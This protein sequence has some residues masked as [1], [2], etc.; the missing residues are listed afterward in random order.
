[1]FLNEFCAHPK[2]E[3]EKTEMPL[4]EENP[5]IKVYFKRWIILSIFCLVTVMNN[6]NWIEHNIIQDVTVAFYN[7]SLPEGN[8]HQQTAVNWLSMVYMLVYIP[9]IFPAMYFLDRKG[10]KLTVLLGASLTFL[11]AF[12]KCF[13]V[14][15]NLF[16]VIM[17]G[18]TLCSI[19]QAFILS[20]PARLSAVWFGSNEVAS[21]TAIGVLGNQLG[22][23]I[24]F[25]VPPL[26]VK[27]G[28]VDDMKT[29]FYYLYISNA[30]VCFVMTLLTVFCKL[31]QT[32]F[33]LSTSIKI[34]LLLL[35]VVSDQPKIPPSLSQLEV[36]SERQIK[37]EE[38]DFFLFKKSVIALLKN[39][40]FLLVFVSYGMNVGV[41]YAISTLLNQ[42]ISQYYP[43]S[44]FLKY[45]GTMV[46]SFQSIYFRLE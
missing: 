23:A 30:A 24:G 44:S 26:V 21:A 17:L 35:K 19:A 11:G 39:A 4:D 27:L 45:L 25:L 3:R 7:E 9:T 16:P 22:C 8:I 10:L 1:M 34:F 14:E 32:K 15:P 18:Q 28:E 5:Q 6:F 12:V 42:I 29:Q 41:F 38:S 40:N 31:F 13:A 2:T 46:V 43:V 33:L 36:R 37:R 20:I